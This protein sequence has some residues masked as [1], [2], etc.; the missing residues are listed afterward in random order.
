[1][2][3]LTLCGDEGVQRDKMEAGTLQADVNKQISHSG[4]AG[5]QSI[6]AIK[7][8]VLTT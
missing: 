4:E 3:E 7:K 6:A 1:M 8:L 5:A 2:S